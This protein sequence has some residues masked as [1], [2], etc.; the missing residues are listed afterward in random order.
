MGLVAAVAAAAGASRADGRVVFA[1]DFSASMTL[2]EN[3]R[4]KNDKPSVVDGKLRLPSGSQEMTWNGV[5]PPAFVL[6]MKMTVKPAWSEGGRKDGRAG[7]YFSDGKRFFLRG[8]G[9]PWYGGREHPEWIGKPVRFS[10]SRTP[11]GAGRVRYVYS[12]NGA[13]VRDEM[14]GWSTV[15]SS[16]MPAS[17]WRRSAM[18]PGRL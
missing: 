5:V 8:D 3:W 10:L 6:E 1:D 12:I 15:F 16:P 2:Q 11:M 9:C 4:L 17:G 13:L 18:A 7:V 14:G